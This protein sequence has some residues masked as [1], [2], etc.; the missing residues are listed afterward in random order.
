[1]IKC[2]EANYPES[3]GAVLV[4]RAPWLFSSV[5]KIIKGWLDPVVAS[6]IHFTNNLED[7]S[8]FI[9]RDQV[10]KELGGPVDFEYSYTEPADDENKCMADTATRD[11]LQ[12]ERA[13][14]VRQF[15]Q[16]TLAWVIAHERPSDASHEH[17]ARISRERQ[18]IARDLR[19]NYWE[20]DPYLRARSLYD[21]T[22]LLKDFVGHPAEDDDSEGFHTA[23]ATPLKVSV[24]VRRSLEVRT[25]VNG[26][27][28]SSD[29]D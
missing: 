20:L 22:G 12:Q 16:K 2:F 7:L 18:E 11:R 10:I 26:T 28:A 5:W 17:R 4:H 3:L 29:V 6:K 25:K 13:A 14:I 15:E 23:P 21:R 19:E 27:A 1:M 24:E 8:Q 9:D